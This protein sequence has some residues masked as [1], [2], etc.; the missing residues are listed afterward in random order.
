MAGVVLWVAYVPLCRAWF[1][2]K[3]L[4]LLAP[5]VQITKNIKRVSSAVNRVMMIMVSI[6]TSNRAVDLMNVPITQVWRTP[7]NLIIL[8]APSS[9]V[10]KQK[11]THVNSRLLEPEQQG[12]PESRLPLLICYV[13]LTNP[14]SIKGTGNFSINFLMIEAHNCFHARLVGVQQLLVYWW[15]ER[16]ESWL[17]D[18]IC[19]KK[20]INVINSYIKVMSNGNVDLPAFHTFLLHTFTRNDD[21]LPFCC[22]FVVAVSLS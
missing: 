13:L 17:L 11:Q 22:S 1:E 15:K 20:I 14:A 2:C 7:C 18:P 4:E 3:S 10:T 21:E 8:K 6:V 9:S 16:R 19:R 5:R 12:R